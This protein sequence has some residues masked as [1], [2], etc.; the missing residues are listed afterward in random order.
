MSNGAANQGQLTQ[1]WLGP[2]SPLGPPGGA[3]DVWGLSVLSYGPGYLS[4][5][6]KSCLVEV[7]LGQG[8]HHLSWSLMLTCTGGQG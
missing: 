4:L 8:P 7:A 2:V 3:C 6:E 1:G 5:K